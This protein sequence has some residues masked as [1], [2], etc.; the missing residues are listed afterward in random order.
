MKYVLFTLLPSCS[1]PLL[2]QLNKLSFP[3]IRKRGLSCRSSS[4]RLIKTIRLR[5][6]GLEPWIYQDKDIQV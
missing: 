4:P 2:Q 6:A 1:W 3:T 5:R